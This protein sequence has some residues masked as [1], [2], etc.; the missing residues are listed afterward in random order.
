MKVAHPGEMESP[1]QFPPAAAL[2]ALLA[3]A[4]SK[5]EEAIAVL[6]AESRVVLWNPAAEAMTGYRSA[7]L[8]SRRFPANLYRVDA[9]RRTLPEAQAEWPA[10]NTAPAESAPVLVTLRHSLG[11]AL[12]GM[13]RSTPLRDELGKRF[14]T[15]LRFHPVEEI[16]ALPRGETAQD[17]DHE[18]RIEQSQMGMEDRLDE[19]WQEWK[20]NA[21]PFGLLW[22]TVDQAAGLRRTHGRDAVEAML[23]IVERTLLHALRPA[24]ILGR[25]GSNEFLVLSHERSAEMLAAHAEHVAAL[26]RTADFRWWGDRVPLTVSI[27]GAQAQAAEKL[28]GLLLGAQEAMR[29]SES[30][31]GNDVTISG[32]GGQ[33]CSQS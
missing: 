4:L 24:E 21:V 17:E 27:G 7:D 26:A 30:G 3:A 8:I 15:L 12:P 28:S 16:D 11:H 19:A 25:W 2:E 23:A 20:V 22:I 29:R 14:G 5:I 9:E 31:G 32:V 13:L 18:H 10:P 6:D 33:A 1:P